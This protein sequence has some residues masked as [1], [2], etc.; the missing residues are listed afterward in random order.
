MFICVVSLSNFGI[1]IVSLW[2]F[3]IGVLGYWGFGIG[4]DNPGL[5]QFVILE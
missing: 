2:F 4:V 1:G 5:F 3:G